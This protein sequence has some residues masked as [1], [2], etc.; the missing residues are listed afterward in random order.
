MGLNTQ[1]K[2]Y[3]S[4]DY[5]KPGEDYEFF[6]LPKWNGA[7]SYTIPLNEE[8]ELRAYRLATENI[9]IDVHEHANYF[10]KDI[11][12]TPAYNRTGRHA[13]AFDGLAASCIDCVFDNMMDGTCMIT[14]KAGWK[15]RDVIY[16]LGMRLCDIAHQ[17]FVIPCRGVADIRRAFAEGK[18]A[19]V[20]VLEGA[21]PI[22]NEVDRID[23]LYG[24][25]IRQMGIT[26]SESNALGSGMKEASDG[27]LTTFGRKCV[28]RMNDVGMLLD[29]SHCGKKTAMDAIECSEKPIIASHTGA[30]SLWNI[31]R[32]FDDE[33]LR[34]V[35][36][37]GGV[38]GVEAAPHTTMTATHNTHD[39]Y[40]VMEHFEYIVDLVG[41]DHVS[42]GVDA[43]YGDHVGLHEVYAGSLG[44]SAITAAA[45][46]TNEIRF[47]KGMENPTEASWNIIRYL[48]SKN[49]SDEDIRKV[50][51]EN[52]LR[53][54]EQVWK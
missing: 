19:W 12:Q 14:S 34:K 51:G 2:G 26:Y 4:F 6:E 54:L 41:I 44:K 1:Y 48:V 35:A 18:I 42:F 28:K 3:H 8:Q 5:I 29:V 46:P 43:V 27:G 11:K 30:R 47:V 33:L 50:M 15:W 38:I 16:D 39:I 31:K 13:T 20:P 24:L 25:G 17:D 21:A 52:T 9:F 10:P 7:G 36:E 45:A 23:V 37:H 40:S 49:Y 32:L 53:V 22:E